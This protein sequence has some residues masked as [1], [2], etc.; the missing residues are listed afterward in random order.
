MKDIRTPLLAST[1]GG[2]VITGS[3]LPWVSLFAGLE[4]LPGTSGSFGRLLL[5][6]GVALVAV[7]LLSLRIRRDG[8]RW[9]TGLLGGILLLPAGLAILGQRNVATMDPLLV[10][11]AGPGPW[12]AAAG[13]ALGLLALFLRPVTPRRASG[14]DDGSRESPP[15]PDFAGVPRRRG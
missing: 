12:V 2:L 7:G 10:A 4:R 9:L 11:A 1:A 5:V 13:A 6:G 3:L 8:L 14:G 15:T